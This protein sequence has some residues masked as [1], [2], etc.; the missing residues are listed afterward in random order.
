MV[1]NSDTSNI[2]GGFIDLPQ[3][4][5]IQILVS[6]AVLGFLAWLLILLGD[7]AVSSSLICGGQVSCSTATS[8]MHVIIE[9][10]VALV[11]LLGLVRLSVY[12]PLMIVIAATVALWGTASFA[13]GL[14][15]YVG[16]IWSVILYGLV[17]LLFAWLVRPRK[18]IPTIILLA[19]VVV[20]LR[21]VPI[22]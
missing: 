18:L 19:L 4:Q 11:A 14:V 10:F 20:L 12:R 3:R 5:F 16:L 17:Y 6:G 22:L 21:V 1:R 7:K 13:A 9:L 2:F 15:W 8:T